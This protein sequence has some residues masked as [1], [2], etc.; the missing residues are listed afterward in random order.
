MRTDEGLATA[1]QTLEGW[2]ASSPSEEPGADASTLH[3]HENWNL[4]TVARELVRAARLRTQSCGA[5]H[6]ADHDHGHHT[7]QDTHERTAHAEPLIR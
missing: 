3:D 5:H 2:F 4:L 1:E 6:R 7:A